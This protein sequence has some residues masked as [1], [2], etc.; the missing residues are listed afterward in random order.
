MSREQ[1][2]REQETEVPVGTDAD[3]ARAGDAAAGATEDAAAAADDTALAEAGLPAEGGTRRPR[4]RASLVNRLY[5]GEAG[6]DVVGRSRLIYKVTAVVVLVCIASM[7]F[8]GF[9]FG[10]DFAGGNSF[11]LPGTT[12]QL[13]EVREAA[14]EAGA[15]VASAQVVGGNQ[16]LLRT[17]GLDNA[18]ERAVVEAVAGTVGVAPDEV[19][20]ESVS[21]EWGQDITDQALLA[22]AVFLVAVIAF[23][24]VRFQPKMAIGAILALLHDLVV[25]AGVYSLIGF[26]VTPST[27]IGLLTILGFSLYDT[28]VVF[29]KVDE[30][31]R[32]LSSSA[33]MTW[34]E[35][36]NLAVNQTLMRSINTS[37]IALLPVAGLLFVGAGLLGVGTLKDL[38]LVLFVGLAAGA[39]SSIFLAT[40]IVA[41]LKE[42]EPE[43][44]AL[45]RRV[46]ARRSAAARQGSGTTPGTV[47]RARRARGPARGGVALAERDADALGP[48]Q[49][50]VVVESPSSVAPEPARTPG[51]RGATAAPR[52]G[53]RPGGRPG[54]KR[55][56]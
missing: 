52:P 46:L 28:V 38:A 14:T 33:R 54:G 45:R 48:A 26:E 40:P 35:A 20:P 42:R 24:A 39:Y 56:R 34:G 44:Q 47:A 37:V 3:E 36:A 53:Q 8:R 27:V 7:V 23:L 32:G 21:A 22:L 12:A 10:I 43:V 17:G 30:N 2:T 31:T 6:L 4:R 50:D 49:A 18:G 55:R 15:D 11:R 16:I 41:D 19:S 25:T 1:D 51:P 29:D 5:N 9:N 13:E